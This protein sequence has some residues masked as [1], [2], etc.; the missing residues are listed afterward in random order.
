MKV[1]D[2]VRWIVERDGCPDLCHEYGY[3][4]EI[5]GIVID[6]GED[7]EVKV[8]FFN[9]QKSQWCFDYDLEVVNEGR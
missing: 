6:H 5:A 8:W 9:G 4:D 2:L 1:G 3:T 7:P